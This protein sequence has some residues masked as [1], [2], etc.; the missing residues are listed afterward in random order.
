[1]WKLARDVY[2][3]RELLGLLVA[4]NLKIRYKNSALG[5]L[6]SLLVPLFMILIYAT[7]ASILKFNLGRPDYIQFLVTGL[8]VWQFLVMCVNDSLNSIVGSANLVKK[9]AFP[10]IVLPSAM[11]V[12]NLINFLLTCVVLGA[13]LLVAKSSFSYLACLPL[14]VIT[15]CALCLGMAMI[16]SASNVF[17]RDTEHIVGVL[18][19]A[20]FFLSPIFYSIDM[21]VEKLS[22][23]VKGG[24]WLP[25]LNPLSGLLCSYRAI[26]I[27][28][29]SATLPQMLVSYGVAWAVLAVGIVV[30]QRVQDRF[31]DEL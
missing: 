9:T 26:L 15:Q 6:W 21:Q 1:M 22:P 27:S 18:T 7:F 10:R 13:Y 14:V 25:F 8:I 4:R 16:L 11:V 20:W 19:L 31:A 28:D 24:A 23:L 5:F 29:F 12:A 2:A 30:F 17:F 3:R